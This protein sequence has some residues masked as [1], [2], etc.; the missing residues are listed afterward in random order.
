M[1]IIIESNKWRIIKNLFK[2]TIVV[3]LVR[4]HLTTIQGTQI[5]TDI[6]IHNINDINHEGCRLYK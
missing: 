4:Q 2:I 6:N 1:N 5:I 3:L